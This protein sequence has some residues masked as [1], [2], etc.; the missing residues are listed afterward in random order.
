MQHEGIACGM[1]MRNDS[2]KK[3]K[4]NLALNGVG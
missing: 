3:W 1:F 4:G 2:G